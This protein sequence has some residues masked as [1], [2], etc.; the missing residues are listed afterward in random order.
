MCI[1]H[2]RAHTHTPNNDIK[3]LLFSVLGMKVG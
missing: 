1:R 2:A 3:N